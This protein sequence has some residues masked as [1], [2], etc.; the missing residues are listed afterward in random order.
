MEPHFTLNSRTAIMDIMI[1][2]SIIFAP[3]AF[4]YHYNHPK[5]GLTE[6][7]LPASVLEKYLIMQLA[8]ILVGPLTII[9][10]FGGMD[11]LLALLFP[12]VYGGFAVK[13]VL[14]RMPDWNNLVVTFITLQALLFCN[15][16]FVRRKLLKTFVTCILSMIFVTIIFAL[17][18]VILESNTSIPD[19]SGS[20]D[21]DVKNKSLFEFHSDDHPLVT[22]IQ[23][24][25]IF[26]TIV[27]PP[28]F[29]LGS[30]RLL[31]TKRY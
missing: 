11:S 23:A 16:L 2:F 29:I 20:I 1:T 9:V 25:R 8:C 12:N 13:E 21:L 28:L 6:V 4:F 24:F 19:F 22:F 15:L 14:S 27:L 7:M 3:F 30:Y 17:F 26:F 31:K 10:L 5:K 18:I